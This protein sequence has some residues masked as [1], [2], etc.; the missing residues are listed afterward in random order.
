MAL[1]RVERERITDSKLK[2]QAITNSLNGVDPEKVPHF[3]QIQECLED[4][5]QRLAGALRS[6][7]SDAPKPERKQ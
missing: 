5:D 6:S 7:E 4:A 3:E 2:I 1:T